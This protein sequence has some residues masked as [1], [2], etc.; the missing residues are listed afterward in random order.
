MNTNETEIFIPQALQ[1]VNNWCAWKM[2]CVKGR[3]TKIPYQ[4]NGQRASSTN[5]NTWS[6]YDTITE[7]L[8]MDNQ[9]A[10]YGFMVTDGI[11]FIDCDH[12]INADGSIDERGKD[13]L[14]A[15]PDSF[16][17]ISQSGTGIHILTRGTIP[18]SFHNQKHGV[19]MYA[20]GR[21]CAL[22]GDCIQANEP[23]EEQD[24]VDFVYNK[25]GTLSAIKS[26]DRPS[27]PTGISTNTDRWVIDHAMNIDGQQGRNFRAL[28]AGDTSAYG[29][30]SEA[31]SALCTLLAFWCDRDQGQMDRIF[32][33]SGLYRC[34]WERTDYRNRT[35]SHA[36]EHIPESLSEYQR[37][38]N[39][40]KARAIAEER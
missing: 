2:E 12:C 35:I 18:R 23:T 4:A 26:R 6:A 37:R 20:S 15:F 14:S 31:D 25:Y 29:S 33:K 8:A 32:R 27:L 38:M 16:A 21:F 7:L 1:A 17:E 36:C 40:E 28:F 5:R 24:G 19:E 34:K 3:I 9:Y 39:R 13:I 22:T 10:G 30:A 11:V